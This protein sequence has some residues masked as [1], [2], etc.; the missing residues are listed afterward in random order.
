MV[1]ISTMKS[2]DGMLLPL[3]SCNYNALGT[4]T[5]KDIMFIK[6]KYSKFLQNSCN[7]TFDDITE[8]AIYI[9]NV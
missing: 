7:A 1:S 4:T 8:E 5:E 3:E 9:K 6:I 2:R